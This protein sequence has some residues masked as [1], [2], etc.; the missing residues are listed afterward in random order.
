M[1]ILWRAILIT[2]CCFAVLICYPAYAENALTI[3]LTWAGMAFIIVTILT[4]LFKA[5]LIGKI[6]FFNTLFDIV[7][8][9]AFLYVLLLIF[10]QID[11]KSPISKLKKGQ[12]PTMQE[13]DKGLAKLGLKT[14]KETA[15]ELQQGINQI[16]NNVNEVKTLILKEHKD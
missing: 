9:I 4:I 11:G 14:N 5:L 7:F 13:I 12:Y 6:P 15:Q 1:L 3:M 16:S 10:P 2:V 8:V